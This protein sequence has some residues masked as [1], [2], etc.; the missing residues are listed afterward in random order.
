LQSL[1]LLFTIALCTLSAY[2]RAAS[3]LAYS[4]PAK[5]PTNTVKRH[6]DNHQIIHLLETAEAG[7]TIVTRMLEPAPTESTALFAAAN[8]A[9]L[10]TRSLPKEV[11]EQRVLEQRKERNFAC[12][13]SKEE[14]L[15]STT[16]LADL[17]PFFRAVALHAFRTV[18]LPFRAAPFLPCNSCR[19][20]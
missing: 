16:H 8:M 14:N 19:V 12:K 2:T 9:A 13:T 11:K 18:G 1:K 4:V 5:Y 10:K 3:R 7:A 6:A 20:V 15:P 17:F